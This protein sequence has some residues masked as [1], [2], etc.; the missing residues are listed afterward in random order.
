MIDD[1]A[2]K[3]LKRQAILRNTT[4]VSSSFRLE[5]KDISRLKEGYDLK[6]YKGFIGSFFR[7]YK[8]MERA[9]DGTQ[10]SQA[11]I[12]NLFVLM[13]NAFENAGVEF[14]TPPVGLNYRDNNHLFAPQPRE[15]ETKDSS[16][17]FLV[18]K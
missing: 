7:L 14:F 12:E 1:E 9:K 11:G 5:D 16:K 6:L 8:A 3:Q 17:D 4:Q 13:E 2:P 15:V 18:E 10:L